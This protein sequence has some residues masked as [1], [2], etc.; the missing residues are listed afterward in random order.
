M[1]LKKLLSA[2][3]LLVTT[4]G[5]TAALAATELTLFR[6]FGGCSDEYANVTD[7]S[8]AVGECGIIQVL[9]NKFNAENKEGI[10][11]KTQSVEWGVYYDRLS[12][13]M[14]GGNPPDI[15]VMHRSV[16]P[17]YLARDLVQP[18]GKNFT[19]AGIGSVAEGM[20]K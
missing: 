5:S 3:T 17:N 8:K 9:T 7:L 14:A 6:F 18:L 2:A 4:L 10:T 11:I 19:A 20:A 1:K 15:A 16:L 13:G 12:A